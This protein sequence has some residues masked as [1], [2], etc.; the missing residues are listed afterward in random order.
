VRQLLGAQLLS[1]GQPREAEAVYRDDLR[2]NPHNG[3][4]LYGLSLALART[5]RAAEAARVR[6]EQQL[7]WTH[8]DVALPGSAFWYAGVD[9]AR[10][11]CEHRALGHGQAGGQLLRTQHEAG[12]D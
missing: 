7:A 2:R 6:R 1:A 8:A 4:S 3:W 11:E 10:C 12:I 5:G 9:T